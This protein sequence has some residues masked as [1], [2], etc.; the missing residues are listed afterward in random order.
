MSY[1]STFAYI[2][3]ETRREESDIRIGDRPPIRMPSRVSNG[4]FQPMPMATLTPEQARA[5]GWELYKALVAVDQVLAERGQ[6]TDAIVVNVWGSARAT[7]RRA[8]KVEAVAASEPEDGSDQ[9]RESATTAVEAT[10]NNATSP[11]A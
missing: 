11:G 8:S 9:Q 5:A 3:E 10:R 7:V 1:I 4:G 6:L 2:E